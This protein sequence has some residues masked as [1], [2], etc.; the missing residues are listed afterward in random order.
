ME[1]FQYQEK[2]FNRAD[3]IIINGEGTMHH[4]APLACQYL[5]L[6]LE[7][8]AAK[9][10]I[11]LINTVWQ[12]MYLS[13]PLIEILQNSYISVRDVKSQK[14]LAKYN[15]KSQCHLDLSYNMKVSFPD[16]E[17]NGLVI[18]TFS[19]DYDE[20]KK[21]A[22]SVSLFTENWEDL[23]TRL[24]KANY[25]IT[26][27]HHEMIAACL[28]QCPFYVYQGNSWKNEGLL[29]TAGAKIPCRKEDEKVLDFMKGTEGATIFHDEVQEI[30]DNRQEY[31]KLFKWMED[32]KPFT[33]KGIV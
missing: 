3:A 13:T 29:E 16:S 1:H 26:S 23:V 21:S 31:D 24:S 8:E 4:N 25:F 12:D 28:A 27:R 6:I 32:Q 30:E 15:I 11:F 33:F 5:N 10:K 19:M 22:S 7:A 17:R 18:G 14:E 20:R 9:K 2:N